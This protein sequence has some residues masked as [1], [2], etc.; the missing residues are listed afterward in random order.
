MVQP[1][2]AHVWTFVRARRSASQ[3]IESAPPAVFSPLMRVI[4]FGLLV[5]LLLGAFFVL[6][7]CSTLLQACAAGVVAGVGFFARDYCAQ[8]WMAAPGR[9]N[10]VTLSD[11]EA[12]DGSEQME[13]R[14]SMLAGSRVRSAS[15]SPVDSFWRDASDAPLPPLS[16]PD[17]EVRLR[18]LFCALF[19]LFLLLLLGATAVLDPQLSL[20]APLR[21]CASL[22]FALCRLLPISVCMLLSSRCSLSP[23]A[24]L[25]LLSHALVAAI[26]RLVALLVV[27]WTAAPEPLGV[28]LRQ[29]AA[30]IT[31]V[32]V[33]IAAMHWRPPAA[34]SHPSVAR[35]QTVAV[36]IAAV[37]I[38]A[39]LLFCTVT[40]GVQ[41]PMNADADACVDEHADGGGHFSP[42]S[43]LSLSACTGDWLHA[44]LARS[45]CVRLINLSACVPVDWY[46]QDDDHGQT[47]DVSN[48]A[49]SP[50][51][52]A[53]AATGDRQP[54]YAMIIR[55]MVRTRATATATATARADLW[56][57]MH[58]VVRAHS[59]GRR[60][61]L[62]P[63]WHELML[64]FLILLVV[65]L[66][67]G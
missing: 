7:P 62:N 48:P 54:G 60:S 66:F 23:R 13:E 19:F 8:R 59:I 53:D 4:D 32:A 33:A 26:A 14:Q 49:L 25:P 28:P 44:P 45:P 65:Y 31:M 36:R 18:A 24:S 9:L 16:S 1:V 50:V 42:T 12:A 30:G 34:A 51:W 21:R 2:L 67:V 55:T 64:L 27:G 11:A 63:G 39:V 3:Q 46:H 43:S 61:L 38:G 47:M 41:E 10:G 56:P 37:I 22:S 35:R 29:L 40:A 20:L 6:L 57:A 17:V 5:V 15:L 58:D 52:I